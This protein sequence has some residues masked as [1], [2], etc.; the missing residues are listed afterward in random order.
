MSKGL[1][2]VLS[3]PS[4]VGKGTIYHRLLE[5]VK[6]LTVSVSVTTRAPRAGEVNGVHY[7]F[8]TEAEFERMRDAGEL[9]E[10]AETVHN[11]YGTPAK[12]V[13]EKLNAGTDVLLEIDVKGARQI[14]KAC[15]DCV[16]IFVLPPDE[17]ELRRRLTGRGTETPEQISARLA[18]AKEE[19]KQSGSFDYE[20]VND[21]LERAVEEIAS[22]IESEKTKRS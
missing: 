18:L 19:I 15:P 5:V 8:I 16:T 20:V 10:W 17:E 13:F 21:D 22:V 1:L 7:H 9:L 6:G 2:I 11:H 3:G 14:K 12:Y 4:G